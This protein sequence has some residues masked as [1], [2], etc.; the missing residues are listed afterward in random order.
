MNPMLHYTIGINKGFSSCVLGL[1]PSALKGFSPLKTMK[2]HIKKT[3]ANINRK[4]LLK[5][6]P[7]CFNGE[8]SERFSMG[9]IR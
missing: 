5:A 7:N 8:N 2:S 6:R 3:L 4:N 1:R 9:C